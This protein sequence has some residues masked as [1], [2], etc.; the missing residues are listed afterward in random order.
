MEKITDNIN[1]MNE[2]FEKLN[3]RKDALE[4]FTKLE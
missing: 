3:I 1:F 4:Y 2:M